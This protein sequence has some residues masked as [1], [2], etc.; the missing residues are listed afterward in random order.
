MKI[1]RWCGIG[2]TVFRIYA[3]ILGIGVLLTG[4]IFVGFLITPNHVL[5]DI[6][7]ENAQKF[8]FDKTN[9]LIWFSELEIL[10]LV[11]FLI[12][13]KVGSFFKLCQ[14]GKILTGNSINSLKGMSILFFILF[15]VQSWVFLVNMFFPAFNAPFNA[16]GTTQDNIYQSFLMK[17][18]PWFDFFTLIPEGVTTLVIGIMLVII[19]KI[20]SDNLVL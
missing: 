20:I 17:A 13:W 19:A 14:Q 10:G 16:Q 4:L 7:Q 6:F 12:Y 15:A 2:K 5:S 1:R 9:F 11:S 8:S 3:A 18:A